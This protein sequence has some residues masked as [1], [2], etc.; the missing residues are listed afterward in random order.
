MKPP[1]DYLIALD[2]EATCDENYA[3]PSNV[4]V[5][6]GGGEII[7]VPFVVIST[8]DLQKQ[9]EPTTM[10]GGR[11]EKDQQK[12]QL[13]SYVVHKE[14]IYVRPENTPI[15]PYCTQLTGITEEMVREAV[16][17]H[18]AL[19]HVEQWIQANILDQKKTFAFVTHGLEQYCLC[20][21]DV[22]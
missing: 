12:K 5:P 1:F 18:K 22:V 13:P 16:S 11:E 8:K 4:R 20:L 21:C 6:R 10:T 7:E 19:K 2:F 15:T 14:H 9:E 3:D 17:L